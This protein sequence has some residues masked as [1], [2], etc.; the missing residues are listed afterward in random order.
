M[1]KLTLQEEIEIMKELEAFDTP[2][3]TNAVA[4][5]PGKADC[6][7][8][9]DPQEVNWYTD[10]RVRALFPELG[11]RCGFAVTV[12]YGMVDPAYN[13]LGMVDILTAVR[14]AEGPVILL[15]KENF[16]ERMKNKNALMGGNMLTAFS[17]SGVV[18]VIG[19][20]PARD[21]E[22]M[23][24]LGVPCLFPGLVPGHGSMI[25]QAVN[26][27][28]HMSGMDAAPMEIIHM[29]VNG[30]VKFPR[31]YLKQVLENAR[32]IAAFDA[33][34]QEAMRRMETPEELAAAI[35]GKF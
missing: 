11:P 24:P 32:H 4:T 17:R 9:Y 30:A 18:G 34:R 20:A 21:L 28:V 5:F 27:P 33:A 3:I 26:V 22:E 12:V 15:L 7:G 13:Q 35:A 10:N 16:T 14:E 25:V 23:R 1:E 31:K 8:I 2:T 29:D 19:D 6:L